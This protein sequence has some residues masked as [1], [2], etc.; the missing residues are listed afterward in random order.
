[1][2]F[3][4]LVVAVVLGIINISIKPLLLILTL[5]L[6]VI[7]LGLFALVINALLILLAGKIVPGFEIASFWWA[8]L[9]SIV[10]AIING[11]FRKL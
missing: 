8:V 6:T 7:T 5:P 2:F 4:A 11:V 3:T 1:N 10:L 9:F